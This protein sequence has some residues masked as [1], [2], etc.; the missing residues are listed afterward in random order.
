MPLIN[1]A[2]GRPL[3]EG[4]KEQFL[5]VLKTT[6]LVSEA[7][8]VVGIHRPTAY[9][10]REQ[11]PEFAERWQEVIESSTDVLEQICVRRAAEG[12]DQLMMFMLKARRPHIYRE[13]VQ[14][15]H[16]HNHVVGGEVVLSLTDG[17]QPIDISAAQRREAAR[18]L[19][20]GEAEEDLPE[21]IEDDAEVVDGEAA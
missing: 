4:W 6:N 17:R 2:A 14:V 16:Q 18:A 21:V 13:N 19:L 12:S 7:C 15:E 9:R 5:D 20:A 10:H 1:S 8:K 3:P 11:D